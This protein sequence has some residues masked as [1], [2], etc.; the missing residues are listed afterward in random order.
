MVLGK[1]SLTR[2][3]ER[4]NLI[5]D[6][7]LD[8]IKSASYDL[9]IGAIYKGK[10]I[11]SENYNSNKTR[12]EIKP[13]EIITLLTF[14]AVKIPNDCC[15]TVFAI[16]KMSSKGFLIL[17]P[18]H[19]DPGFYGP[20]SICA[21]NLSNKSIFLERKQSIFTL[22]INKLDEKLNDGDIYNRNT[23]K[24]SD[25]KKFERKFFDEKYSNLS[26]SFFD[27]ISNHKDGKEML[28]NILKKSIK[29]FFYW[30]VKILTFIAVLFGIVKGV[31]F[32]R[33]NNLKKENDNLKTEKLKLQKEQKILKEQREKDS[34]N[35]ILTQKFS[36]SKKSETN[37]Q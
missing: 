35:L 22:I 28:V 17:N 21:I 18:G 30:V 19:I 8:N 32:F 27:L 10:K 13:S 5:D 9:R 14:E 23:Y 37:E 34:I 36:E 20:I 25:R 4:E 16:N 31:A 15:G 33:D 1:P 2:L 3:I 24:S 29:D 12:I 26:N 6:Y 7:S 11:Y